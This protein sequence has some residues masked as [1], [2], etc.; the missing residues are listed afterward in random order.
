MGENSLAGRA[1][2]PRGGSWLREILLDRLTLVILLWVI[3]AFV[4]RPIAMAAHYGAVEG[5]PGWLAANTGSGA[6]AR[7]SGS[8]Q[9]ASLAGLILVLALG[10]VRLV[11]IHPNLSPRQGFLI[12]VGYGVA[13]TV[14]YLVFVWTPVT[15]VSLMLHDT[16]IFYDAIHRIE[17]GQRPSVDFPTPLGAAML[18]LPWLGYKLS[19]GYAGSIEISSAIVALGLCVACAQGAAARHGPA[20]TAVLVTAVF[21]IVVPSMLEGYGAPVSVSLEDG[22]LQPVRGEYANAMF[23]NRWGWGALIAFFAF[24][25]PRKLAERAPL[26]EIVT[27]GLMLAFL[28]WLKLSYFMIGGAAALLYAF[29][30]TRPWRTLAIGG[31]VAAAGILLVALFTGNLFAYVFDILQTGKVSGARF[32]NVAE[33]IKISALH[34]LIAVAPFV[35]LAVLKKLTATDVWIAGLMVGGTLFIINQNAQSSGLP[36]LLVV[37]AYAIWR[38]RQEERGLVL[39]AA[40]AFALPASV[41]VLERGAGLLAQT[42]L[43][44][45]E[46]ARPQAPWASIP[47]LA[48]VYTQER[49]DLLAPLLKAEDERTRTVAFANTALYGRR[50]FLRSGEYLVT[51]QAGLE[52]LR[53]VLDQNESVAVLDFASPLAFLAGA[54]SPKG[55]WITFDDGRTISEDVHPDAEQLL[56]DADHVMAPRLFVEPDTAMRLRQLY[57]DWLDENYAERVET[58][59]WTRWSHRKPGLRGAT[60]AELIP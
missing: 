3:T 29:L 33:L 1:A 6:L 43:A 28:F 57:R 13:L 40:L 54:R 42:T 53:P 60:Q 44:R 7:L 20:V 39:L 37:S 30:G 38:V 52:E 35:A 47:A 14:G 25:T 21:L 23:Y 9:V 19:G 59:Y 32:A 55:F 8:L 18:Y 46:E 45:R 16:F 10:H 31:G 2:R 27:L 5:I 56:G 58:L 51:M 12:A 4:L 34:L 17:E 49:E 36:T 24:L 41:Y 48:R 15:A 50:Q 22:E 11:H 26:A